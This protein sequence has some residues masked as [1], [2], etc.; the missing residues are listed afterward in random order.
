MNENR[1]GVIVKAPQPSARGS[2]QSVRS[3]TDARRIRQHEDKVLFILTLMIGAVVGLVVVAFILLTENLGSR[4]Y[5]AGGAAW[6]RLVVPLLGALITGYL[7]K[8]YFPNARGSGIP[9]TKT[10]MFLRG[11]VIKFRTVLGKF[12]LSSVSLA[13]G[14]ALGRE[15][16]S[17]QVGAGI[18]STLG[19]QLGLSPETIKAL[20]PIGSA[21]A[22]S[23]AFN[24]PIAAVLFTLE[25]V[26]GDLHA[27]VL[28]AIVLSSATSWMVLH[29]LLGDEPLFHVPAYQLV[30]PLEFGFYAVLGLIGGIVSVCF[31]KLLLWLRK[32]FLRMPAWT[33]YIQP[34]AGGLLVGVMGWFVPDVLGVGYNHVSEALNGRLAL[35]AMALLVGLKLVATAGCYASGNAGGIFGPSLFI[36]AM[37]GGAF[38]GGA[39]VLLPDYTGSVGAYALVGMG[40]TFAGIIRVPMTSVIM[41]FEITRDYSIIVPL[42]IANLISYFISSRLQKEPIYEALLHQDGIHLPIAARE[43][44]E[45]PRVSRGVRPAEEI[46]SS[47]ET[48]EQTLKTI[49]REIS[50]W[51]VIDGNLLLGMVT[52]AQLDEATRQGIGSN[53]IGDLL[54]LP[55]PKVDPPAEVFPHVHADHPLETAVRRMAQTGLAVL[56]VVSRSNLRELLGVITMNDALA[57]YKRETNGAIVGQPAQGATES[58]IPIRGGLLAVLLVMVALAGFLGYFYHGQRTARAEQNFQQG[59]E[60]LDGGQF[61]EAIERFRSA[62]SISHSNSDR[63][64]LG[65]ALVKAGR[66]NEAAIYLRELIRIEPSSSPANLGLARIAVQEGNAQEAVEY[67]HRAIYGSWP[68][69][70]STN[71]VQTRI[72]LIETLGKLGR[73]TQAQAELLSLM[74]EMPEDITI[75]KQVGGLLLDYGL[76]KESTQVF[77]GLLQK[78]PRDA[79][80]YA[81]LGRA[82]LSLS[83][84]PAAEAAFKNAL[85]WNPG[86]PASKKQLDTVQQILILDPTSH[87]LTSLQRYERSR[88]LMEA[89]LGSLTQCVATAP[90]AIPPSVTDLSD[91]GRKNLLHRGRPSS[92]G[93]ATETN[94]SLAERMWK[95]RSEVC[96]LSSD[97]AL[98]KLMTQLSK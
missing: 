80:A 73:R 95:A 17:V 96:G 27:R 10:A 87:G 40:A 59:T 43:R 55:D 24:T 4:M 69:Q 29:L 77:Q 39:H 65:L 9:Q 97:Q 52:L 58:S 94:I 61:P 19:R 49:H 88:K 30:N 42:M 2:W 71:K 89:V 44:E 13:S 86:D 34:A 6:R 76:A 66:L 12:G 45:S 21:A 1:S 85:R 8:R 31:V 53:R 16:P 81:A 82:E 62:L 23:A 32:Y 47:N 37:M 79:E 63:L 41:I 7:L 67:Y 92:Y 28:G 38:G 56:P 22:L 48:V 83:N 14:I 5:P 70:T 60:L 46:L 72:E 54:P 20:V 11:G 18:A 57:V 91:E 51:P 26:M 50:A 78:Q 36:G 74:A 35:E 15:G 75:R 68:E 84:Y 33:E 93:D 98:A 64:A 90:T 25:E 3:W